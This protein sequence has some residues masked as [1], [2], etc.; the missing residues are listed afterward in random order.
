MPGTDPTTLPL[1]DIHLPDPISWW[2]FAPG[3]WVLL[4]L[5]IV[6]GSLIVFF[7]RRR[8]HYR[9]SAVYL[10]RQELD[11]IKNEFVLNQDKSILVK[12]LSELIRR[13]SISI[14]KRGEAASLTGQDWLGF[15]DQ[16]VE[17]NLFSNGIGRVLIEAPYQDK[18]DYDSTELI[19]L[20]STWI[21]S[22]S[23][24]KRKQT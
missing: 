9:T 17:N 11:S 7:I 2:P 13:L 16:C 20:I 5:I 10:A 8:R 3:W 18:P 14:F 4:L 22:V 15:L 6:T 23:H 1:R 19:T 24:R 12:K 21:E